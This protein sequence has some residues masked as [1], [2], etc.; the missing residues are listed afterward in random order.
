MSEKIFILKFKQ[1]N[2]GVSSDIFCDKYPVDGL[3]LR[4]H[5]NLIWS[6]K[7]SQLGIWGLFIDL[8]SAISKQAMLSH[9]SYLYIIDKRHGFLYPSNFKGLIGVVLNKNITVY[10]IKEAK[11]QPDFLPMDTRRQNAAPLPV[12]NYFQYFSKVFFTSKNEAIY[13]LDTMN[14]VTQHISRFAA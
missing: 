1:F 9:D 10:D 5:Q 6:F 13:V 8:Q 14:I 11:S 12:K 2:A 3:S 4:K 7:S